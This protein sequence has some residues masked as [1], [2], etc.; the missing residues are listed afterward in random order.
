MELY[1]VRHGETDYNSKKL[2]QGRTDIPLNQ[3]GILQAFQTRKKLET[4]SFDVVISSPL[5]RAITTASIIV[6][7]KAVVIDPRLEERGLGEYEGKAS[8]MYDSNLYHNYLI[9]CKE[10]GVEGIRDVIERV[11][12]FINEIKNI[13]ADQTVLLVTH[14]GLVNALLYCFEN[15]PED[16]N[17]RRISL[18]NGEFIKYS[19]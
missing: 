16:G 7:N 15:M 10:S 5:I 17:L 6:P 18:G 13:Y 1:I 2:L 9:N 8:A 11:K 14:G 19:V 12:F 4:I 3:N